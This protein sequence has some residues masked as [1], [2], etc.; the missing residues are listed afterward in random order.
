MPEQTLLYRV[1]GERERDIYKDRKR[2]I[3][4]SLC[5]SRRFYTG[6]RER[7]IERERLKEREKYK[8]R[9]T[10][11]REIGLDIKTEN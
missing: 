6:L 10:R 8:T 11:E 4:P 2:D 3:K 9:E 7:E 5:Q 1:A